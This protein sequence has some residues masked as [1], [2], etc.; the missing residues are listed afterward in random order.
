MNGPLFGLKL[1]LSRQL[2]KPQLA[3][4][5]TIRNPEVALA[6]VSLLAIA[7]LDASKD[8]PIAR[9]TVGDLSQDRFVGCRRDAVRD[10]LGDVYGQGDMLRHRLDRRGHAV[11]PLLG[12]RCFAGRV[13]IVWRRRTALGVAW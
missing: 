8:R 5:A 2:V 13:R 10:P 1:I 3:K 7:A 11:T 12:H 9:L 4:L 6:V